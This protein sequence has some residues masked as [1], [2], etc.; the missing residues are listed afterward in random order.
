MNDIEKIDLDGDG[1]NRYL[2]W[3]KS[4]SLSMSKMNKPNSTRAD[5]LVLKA[6][7]AN[8]SRAYLG[9]WILV[10]LTYQTI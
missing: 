5:K 3:A 2:T 1:L 4:V 9:I 6:S 7:R 10:N 8:L